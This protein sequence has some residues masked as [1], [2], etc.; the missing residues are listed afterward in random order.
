MRLAELLEE[1]TTVTGEITCSLE[2]YINQQWS[3]EHELYG[4]TGGKLYRH[5]GS[6]VRDTHQEEIHID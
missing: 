2:R 6:I 1:N 4:I 3:I 5:R